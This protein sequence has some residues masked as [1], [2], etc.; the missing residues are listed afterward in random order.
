MVWEDSVI[1]LVTVIGK[2]LMI[3][4]LRQSICYKVSKI[5][6]TVDLET[7]IIPD[8]KVVVMNPLCNSKKVSFKHQQQFMRRLQS[9]D[10]RRLV[11]CTGQRLYSTVN[12]ILYMTNVTPKFLSYF[13]LA[14]QIGNPMSILSNILYA[15][16]TEALLRRPSEEQ[17]R[18]VDPI[19]DEPN[20]TALTPFT[21][22]K[23]F[24]RTQRDS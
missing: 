13:T 21:S 5:R 2:I 4:L 11:Q 18:C 1:V 7:H 14:T 20:S 3:K 12:S 15:H 19:I 24:Q 23:P 6:E 22:I 16:H 10:L 9:C 8:F 17:L